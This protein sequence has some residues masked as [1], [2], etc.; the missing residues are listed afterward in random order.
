MFW[1]VGRENWIVR[2]L[3]DRSGAAMIEFALVAPLLF[4]LV[5][6]TIEFGQ[7]LQQHHTLVKSARDATRYLS[8]I[9]MN[10]AGTSDFCCPSTAASWGN[11]ETNARNLA[12]RGSIDPAAPLVLSTWTNPATISFAV[13]CLDNSGGGYRGQA[14]IPVVSTSIDVPYTQIG[15]LSFF[16]IGSIR[17]TA[18]H[19][20]V[21][22]GE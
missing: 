20:E 22:F 11:A 6:G 17:V 9:E 12:M 1:R 15:F 5:L 2:L 16:G 3:P 19:Q 14:V 7:Y 4:S 18:S 21:N 10:C 8:R 13:A